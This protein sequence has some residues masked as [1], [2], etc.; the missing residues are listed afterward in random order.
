V[1]LGFIGHPDG[2]HHAGLLLA[3]NFPEFQHSNL[4]EKKG[5]SNQIGLILQAVSIGLGFTVLPAHAVETFKNPELIS[6]HRLANPVSETIHLGVLRQK[7]ISNRITTVLS[8][9]QN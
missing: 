5:F 2:A 7:P 3:A 8:E 9:S 6:S 1:R 4:F